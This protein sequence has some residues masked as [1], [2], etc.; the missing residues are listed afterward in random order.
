M[1]DFRGKIVCWSRG[2]SAPYYGVIMESELRDS[3]PPLAPWRWHKIKWST[4][5]A[6]EF[7]EDWFRCD[8]VN[9]VD[10]Y[11]IISKLHQAMIVAEEVKGPV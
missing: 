8:H 10:G 6:P 2:S 5:T 3:S 1:K 4:E 9:V 7:T 11:D